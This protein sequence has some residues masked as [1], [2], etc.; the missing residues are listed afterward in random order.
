MLTRKSDGCIDSMP[1]NRR[2]LVETL[3]GCAAKTGRYPTVKA[4]LECR[5]HNLSPSQEL[6]RAAL[7]RANAARKIPFVMSENGQPS[8][9]PRLQF[10]HD[11]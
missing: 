2:P 1:G 10:G 11:D 4:A 6:V 9:R 7:I 5:R 3:L 8:Y